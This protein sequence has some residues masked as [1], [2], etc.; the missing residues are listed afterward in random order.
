MGLPT[1]Q[2]WLFSIKT[3]A[4][5]VLA[6]LISLWIALPNP[7]WAVATVYIA[8]N[9]LSGATRSKAIFRVLGTVIGAA[10]AVVMVPN[11]AN[12]PVLLVLGMAIWITVCLYISLLDRTPRSYVFMLAGYT[13]AL[14]G[15]PTVDA[16]D[17]IFDVALSRAEEI[18][19]GIVCAAVVSSVVFP[20]PVVTA[21]AQ[22]LKSWLMSADASTRDALEAKSGPEADA[23]RLRLAADTGEI[24]N[25]ASHLN[26]D[27]GGHPEL[28]RLIQEIR[29]RML[30]LL[31]ILSSISDGLRE[32]ASLG[33]ASRAVHA[34]LERTEHWLTPEHSAKPQDVDVLRKDIDARIEGQPASRTWRDLIELTLLMRL[35][36]LVAI[37][38]DCQHVVT[39]MEGNT[40]PRPDD[41]AYRIADLANPVRHRDR[42]LALASAIVSF[43]TI[44][45]CCTF[46]ILLAWP[47][48]GVAAMM[49]AVAGALF[50][51][52]DNPVPSIVAFAKWAVIAAISAGVYVF[53]ILPHVHNFET[54]VLALAPALLMTGLF[55]SKP[56]TLL[57]GLS[58]GIN[59]MA[60][61][62]LQVT[63]NVDAAAFINLSIATTFGVGLAAVMTSLL[64]PVG[65]EWSIRRLA[66]ANRAT[67]S[68][69][70]N[71]NDSSHDG[72]LTGLM[73]DRLV[74]LAPRAKAAGH[75]LPDAIGQ[76]RQG[77]NIVD[78]RRAR[79]DVTTYSRRRVDAVL[80]RL[81]R[82]YRAG[83]D[84][85]RSDLLLT[86]INSAI[87]AVR[88]EQGVS[89]R[90]ALL[91][92]V[93]L[94]R[95]LFPGA[96]PPPDLPHTPELLEA[97]E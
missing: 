44:I 30:M 46:W 27:A 36:D 73:L 29:P 19:L 3:F 16:P 95:S 26:Y 79:A 61:L 1:T 22:R 28:P 66:K 50:A 42:G 53:G 21:V 64:R 13:A 57:I 20:R 84:A 8:S 32:L 12:A 62:G 71:S 82:H 87:D 51:A 5:A 41:F 54:L 40:E 25:L 58:L 49:A 96:S 45:V 81:K 6:L 55:I 4:A 24:E 37:R 75:M 72:R 52:Q 69:I 94:R 76:L 89:A 88:D 23:H 2:Q 48:G 63:F 60:T 78:L 56:E 68:E 7:Y 91:G 14:I 90:K 59:F 83:Q 35:R 33:G 85:H 11:L 70:A 97:A 47:E 77:F 38:G 10:A 74:L 9:P 92:L 39:A 43:A 18:I 15:F 65:A 34:L 93:G 80:I 31:P 86:A 17:T 67:L